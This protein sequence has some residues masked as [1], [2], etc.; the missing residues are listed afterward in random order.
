MLVC[1]QRLRPEASPPR[2]APCAH[3]W[4]SD[5]PARANSTANSKPRSTKPTVAREAANRQ[6]IAQVRRQPVQEDVR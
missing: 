5:V 6:T 3:R 2:T 4:R 1:P